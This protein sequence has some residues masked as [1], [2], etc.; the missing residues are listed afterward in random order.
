MKPMRYQQIA[1]TLASSHAPNDLPTGSERIG[2]PR[3]PYVACC[4]LMRDLEIRSFCCQAHSPCHDHAIAQACGSLR[5]RAIDSNFVNGVQ[6]SICICWE[7]LS[8]LEVIMG[9]RSFEASANRNGHA[10]PCSNSNPRCAMSGKMC[11][12]EQ[13][14]TTFVLNLNT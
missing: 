6:I 14:G 8:S 7:A 5:R 13:P 12:H 11:Q 10:A 4:Q 9:L 3:M 1:L 2:L